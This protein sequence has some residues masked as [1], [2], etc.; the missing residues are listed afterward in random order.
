M[1][2]SS[3]RRSATIYDFSAR[4]RAAGRDQRLNAAKP[5]SPAMRVATVEF[6]SGWYHD[7]AIQDPD[8]PRR[9]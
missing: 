1:S 6:G 2:V 7:A 3:E 5:E 4:L 9:Q 8:R